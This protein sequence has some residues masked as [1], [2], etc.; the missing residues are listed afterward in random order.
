MA[1]DQDLKNVQ[2]HGYSF[3]KEKED[4]NELITTRQMFSELN[5]GGSCCLCV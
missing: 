3:F 4:I 5:L 2:E 1:Q